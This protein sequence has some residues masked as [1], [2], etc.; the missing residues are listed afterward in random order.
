[1][2]NILA[3][4]WANALLYLGNIY[5]K[6]WSRATFKWSRHA[7]SKAQWRIWFPPAV[8]LWL[9]LSLQKWYLVLQVLQLNPASIQVIAYFSIHLAGHS[10]ASHCKCGYEKFPVWQSNFQLYIYL[11]VVYEVYNKKTSTIRIILHTKI[12]QW[13]TS[14]LSFQLLWFLPDICF[15]FLTYKQKKGCWV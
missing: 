12:N 3:S 10:Q 2:T 6:S 4:L 5:Y 11:C 1:M 8:T 9:E 15:S 7:Y 13:F 14:S